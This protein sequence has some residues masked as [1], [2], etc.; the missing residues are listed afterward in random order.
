MWSFKGGVECWDPKSL[1][2]LAQRTNGQIPELGW[3]GE[4]GV[5]NAVTG[6]GSSKNTGFGAGHTLAGPQ[7]DRKHPAAATLTAQGH[8]PPLT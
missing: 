7:C 3:H 4:A 5:Q 6:N 2:F 1:R 8:R